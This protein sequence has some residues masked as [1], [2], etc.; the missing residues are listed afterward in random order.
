MFITL[1]TVLC[2]I[3]VMSYADEK[4]DCLGN[5]SNDKRSKDMYCPPDGGYTAEDHKQCMDANAAAYGDCI[6]S[7]SPAPAAPDPA[8][9]PP[10]IFQPT[11]DQPAKP[12]GAGTTD[13]K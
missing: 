4:S 12:E 7:C 10:V 3:T 11:T 9:I 5:C 2:S 13:S 1:V 8:A 6:K